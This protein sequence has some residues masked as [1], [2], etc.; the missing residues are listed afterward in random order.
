MKITDIT[1]IIDT[2][3]QTPLT[4]EYK[5]GHILSSEKGTLYTG[6]YS[7]SGLEDRVAIERKSLDDL[8]GCIGQHRERFEKEIIRLRGYETKAIIIESTWRKIE[9]G[10]YRSRVKPTAAIGT[11]MGWIAGGIPI[12]LAGDHAKAGVFVARM[13][14]ITARRRYNELKAL[15]QL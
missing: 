13:L 2:R 5:P 10:N 7:L 4:L 9:N 14:Y 11:L 6:D 12:V 8:M 3:E 15:G 1:A